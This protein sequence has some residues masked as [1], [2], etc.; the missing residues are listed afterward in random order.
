MKT[1]FRALSIIPMLAPGVALAHTGT[2]AHEHGF[3]YG[4]LH[5]LGGLDH[6]LA[7]IAVGLLAAHLGGRALW[8]VPLSFVALMAAGGAIGFAEI[9]IPYVELLI[10]A[11]VIVLGAL[12]AFRTN[13][14]L[15]AAMLIAGF[16]AIFHG[17]VHGAELPSGESP[18][19]YAAGFLIA[20]ALL[21]IGGIAIGLGLAKLSTSN[22]GQRI[23]QAGGGAM[24]LAGV[25][26][27]TRAL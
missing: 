11:S 15:V 16:F 3:A 8:L 25:V 27:L 13:L 18:L 7:M 19:L 2:G 5:P 26:L 9:R 24:A 20:T 17:H 10:A 22:L 12:V 1:V 14:P 21:H 6:L 4:F 23:V